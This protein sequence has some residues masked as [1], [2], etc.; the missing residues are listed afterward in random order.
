MIDE[1]MKTAGMCVEDVGD[2]AKWRFRTKV[3]DHK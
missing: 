2:W 1:D 3:A